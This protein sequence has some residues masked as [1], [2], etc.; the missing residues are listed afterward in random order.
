[1]CVG[2]AVSS[3]ASTSRNLSALG[4]KDG[5]RRRYTS[6]R[7]DVVGLVGASIVCVWIV[8]AW[9]VSMVVV[10]KSRETKRE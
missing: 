4:A 9:N 8:C 10:S 1:M 7:D 6:K 5:R 3:A 2:A